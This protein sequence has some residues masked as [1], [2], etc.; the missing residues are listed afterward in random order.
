MLKD[1]EVL[2]EYHRRLAYV[3]QMKQQ[4]ADQLIIREDGEADWE[5]TAEGLRACEQLDPLLASLP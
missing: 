4:Y 5:Q 1:M 3:S 2:S